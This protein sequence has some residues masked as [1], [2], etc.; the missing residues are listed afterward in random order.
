MQLAAGRSLAAV[1]F[2]NPTVIPALTKALARKNRG[3]AQSAL[4]EHFE[5]TTDAADFGRVRGD[6]VRL[7][8]IIG[9]V[10]PD[11]R[12]A[13]SLQNNDLDGRVLLLLGRIIAFARLSRNTELQKVIE[14][15]VETYLRGLNTKSPAIRQEVLARLEAIPIRRPEIAL[16]LITHLERSNLAD[17]ERKTAMNALAAQS[18][19]ADST[20]G[21]LE[22]LTPGLGMLAEAL[23]SSE[24]WVRDGRH[25][26]RWDTSAARRGRQST[27]LDAWPGTTRI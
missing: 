20:P 15:A 12:D 8:F 11:L 3:A 18:V 21:M 22:V 1:L 26:A 10:I 25:T 23:D 24:A 4:D 9:A 19:F 17:E 2:E 5:R 27:R 6:L 13:L 14:P 16:A 7:R